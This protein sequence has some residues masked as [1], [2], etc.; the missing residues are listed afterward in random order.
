MWIRA[1]NLK[2]GIVSTSTFQV[3][4]GKRY[5]QIKN[6]WVDSKWESLNDAQLLQPLNVAR[7]RGELCGFYAKN[8]NFF[9]SKLKECRD[10]IFSL[11]PFLDKR[12]FQGF[13]FSSESTKRSEK[14]F[15]TK[16]HSDIVRY[17]VKL[18]NWVNFS[19]FPS[20]G[21]LPY[22]DVSEASRTVS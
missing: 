9:P 19:R 4:P 7:L 1:S 11:N 18:S 20:K 8:C 13:G 14:C 22:C 2:P 16:L 15:L 5:P 10:S 3:F 17:V 12:D 6:S 21:N